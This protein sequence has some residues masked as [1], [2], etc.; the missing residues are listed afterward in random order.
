M[1]RS[2]LTA[3]LSVAGLSA[4]AACGSPDPDENVAEEVERETSDLH[5]DL[6]DVDLS[7]RLPGTPIDAV[8]TRDGEIELGVTDSVLYTRLSPELRARIQSEMAD[9][10]GDE[11]G[12]GRTIAQAVTGAVAQGLAM[13]VSVPLDEVRD[14]RYEDGRLVIEMEDGGESPFDGSRNDDEPMLEQFDREAGE[15]LAEAFDKARGR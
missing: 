13:A 8:S 9:E 11:S 1:R 3:L 6:D 5:F 15:R 4:L 10:T 2:L 14:V 7:S 12:L